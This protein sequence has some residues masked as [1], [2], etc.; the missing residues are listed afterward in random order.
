MRTFLRVAVS[1]ALI[2]ALLYF[3]DI[4]KLAATLATAR[5]SYLVIG[6]CLYCCVQ[7]ASA[8]RW[9]IILHHGGLRPSYQA[10]LRANL[11]GLFTSNF[12]PGVSGGDLVRPLV[13]FGRNAANKT[14]LYA[15]V[16]FE[17]LCGLSAVIALAWLGVAWLGLSRGDWRFLIAAIVVPVGL[18]GSAGTAWLLARLASGRQG[19]LGKTVDVIRR[20]FAHVARFG[21]SPRLVLGVAAL[22]ICFQLA[23]IGMVWSFLAA[24]GPPVRFGAVLIAAPLAWIASMA[25][26]SLNGIGVREGALAIILVQLGVPQTQATAAVFLGLLPLALFSAIGATQAGS[27]MGR[28]LEIKNDR[29]MNSWGLTFPETIVRHRARTCYV[30]VWILIAAIAGGICLYVSEYIVNTITRDEW[31]F[32]GVIKD[33]Y[34]GVPWLHNVWATNSQQRVPGF[35]FYFLVNALFFGLDTRVGNYA[36]IGAYTLFCMGLYVHHIR[37]GGREEKSPLLYLSFVPIVIA[38]FS[39]AQRYYF[40]YDLLAFS[41]LISTALFGTI[42]ILL[43]RH[44]R[45]DDSPARAVGIAGIFFV[46]L[47][48]FGSA[49]GP[50]LVVATLVMGGFAF[51]RQAEVRKQIL[52]AYGCILVASVAAELLYWQAGAS[53][54]HG[55]PLTARVAVVFGDLGGAASYV[56]RALGAS[57]IAVVSLMHIAQSRLVLIIAGACVA[58]LYVTCVIIYL[59][60][61]LYRRTL[62]PVPFMVY[63]AMFVAEILIGRFAVG[64]DNASAPRYTH[65]THYA[66]IGCALVL[67]ELVRQWRIDNKKITAWALL[68]AFVGAQAAVQFNNVSSSVTFAWFARRN[69]HRAVAITKARANGAK[70]VYPGWYCP[71]AALCD[72]DVSFLKKHRLSMFRDSTEPGSSPR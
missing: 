22:S 8:L 10:V 38:A 55:Q 15:T 37:R 17:R 71:D 53:L 31:H 45:V 12:L 63:A 59:Q 19:R 48:L 69:A 54:V 3:V 20:V 7:L 52:L 43:D 34:S 33:Y 1:A 57:A 16:A 70:S 2:G 24:L 67:A 21:R 11:A 66:L 18:A 13:L 4:P 58:A 25:P 46:S 68:A 62:L 49:K 9:T 64:V 56:L 65:Q 6:L 39:F 44:M 41:A 61:R 51:Y 47:L 23:Y 36:G 30:L 32:L 72:A 5:L 29:N 27:I 28:G 14:F 40:S 35:K 50:A 26:V 42:W 60:Q